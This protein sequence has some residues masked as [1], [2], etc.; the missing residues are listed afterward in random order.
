MLYPALFMALEHAGIRRSGV[1]AAVARH[2]SGLARLDDPERAITALRQF[3]GV[4]AMTLTAAAAN[5]LTLSQT[6]RLLESLAA[7]PFKNERYDG[8]LVDWFDRTWLPAVRAPSSSATGATTIEAA[9]AEALAGPVQAPSP[10]IRWEGLDYVVDVAGFER[11][12]LL[13]VRRRQGGITLDSVMALRAGPQPPISSLTRAQ[14][15]GNDAPDCAAR[16][17]EVARLNRCLDFLFAHAVTAWAYAPHVGGADS[18]AMVGGDGSLRHDFGVRS[19][20]RSKFARRWDLP[21]AGSDSGSASGSLLGIQAALAR[22]SLRRVSDGVVPALPTISGNDQSSFMLSVALSNARALSD[23]ALLQ[24]ADAVTRG[25]RAIA[26]ARA[27][28]AR[29]TAAATAAA[30]S[31]WRGATLAWLAENE[32]ER[33]NEQFS[34]IERARLGGLRADQLPAWGAVSMVTGCLCLEMPRARIPEATV[35]RAADGLVAGQSTDLML[36]IA[37][38]LAELKMPAALGTSVLSYAMRGFLDAVKPLHGADFDAF[39]R[40]ARALDRR[41]V[42]DYLAAIAAI[43]PLRPAARQP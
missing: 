28:P 43:G 16:L 40:Q 30:I 13:D 22:W 11:Q 10:L 14:E 32:S 34:I 18:G 42:E 36:R 24:I 9:V 35:G 39:T 25:T 15:F 38:L 19:I 27:D 2:A 23:E 8:R 1:Y 26:D 12:R 37:T 6:E 3:Q 4:L 33:L 31:P 21:S 17:T 20:G 41:T 7:V 5:T 29:L